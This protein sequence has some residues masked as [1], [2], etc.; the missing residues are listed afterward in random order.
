[1]NI[2][3][4]T[5]LAV[6]IL[7]WG[8]TQP[9]GHTVAQP[10]DFTPAETDALRRMLRSEYQGRNPAVSGCWRQGYEMSIGAERVGVTNG[11][12]S[13]KI[14]YRQSTLNGYG[15]AKANAADLLAEIQ[16]E[17]DEKYARRNAVYDAMIRPDPLNCEPQRGGWMVKE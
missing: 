10:A 17:V 2:I 11:Y 9:T 5:A 15:R 13:F 7:A 4:E 8:R 1:M 3:N 14:Y 12:G 6:K 16:A